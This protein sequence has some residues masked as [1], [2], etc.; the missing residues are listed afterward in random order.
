MKKMIYEKIEVP[1]LPFPLEFNLYRIEEKCDYSDSP[2]L[3]FLHGGRGDHSFLQENINIIDELTAGDIIPPLLVVCPNAKTSQYMDF[4]NKKELWE[5][6]LMQDVPAYLKKNYGVKFRQ[7]TT[8]IFG[9]SM[10]GLGALRMAFKYPEKIGI[11]AVIA[12]GIVPALEFDPHVQKQNYFFRSR[13]DEELIFGSPVNQDYWKQNNPI[14]LAV[15]NHERILAHDLKI[16][17]E[18][19]NC[20]SFRLAEGAAFLHAELDK[21]KVKH[22]YRLLHNVD[23]IGPFQ[24]WRIKDSLAFIGRMLTHGTPS[25]DEIYFKLYA[26]KLFSSYE[27]H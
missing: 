15:Q 27:K 9:I 21:L 14:F 4:E 20:D 6:A 12:P 16:Y 10:G 1:S 17:I 23:H 13:Q 26:N 2:F 22:E 7:K 5:T 18:C 24:N 3:Y 19:G 8:C 25:Q 11:V